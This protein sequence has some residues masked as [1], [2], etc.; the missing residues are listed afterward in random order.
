[1]H[2][3]PGT[4]PL[5]RGVSVLYSDCGEVKLLASGPACYVVGTRVH[6]HALVCAARQSSRVHTLHLHQ[7]GGLGHGAWCLSPVWGLGGVAIL[8]CLVTHKVL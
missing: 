6:S 8:T 7:V 1:M 2:G 3:C 4:Q 5:P